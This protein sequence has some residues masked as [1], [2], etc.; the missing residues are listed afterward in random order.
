MGTLRRLI[1]A[2]EEGFFPGRRLRRRLRNAPRSEIA[3]LD[4]SRFARITGLVRPFEKTLL[5]APLS[6]RLCVYYSIRVLECSGSRRR[7]YQTEIGY[8]QE[9][10][11]F[12]L[13]DDTGVAVIDPAH[14]EISVAPDFEC[15]SK[16]AFD[17]D[18]RQRALLERHGLV[19][20]SWFSTERLHYTESIIEA[21]ERI[22]IL[23]AG[24]LEPDLEAAPTGMYRDARPM[25]MRFTGT[26][27]Y[28]LLISDDPRTLG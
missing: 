25:R 15:E 6:G 17:A 24:M 20:R 26:A 21:D 22:A 27:K 18:P 28:P 7:E 4:E 1:R 5:E 12:M 2:F 14:A 13:E 11:A 3:T 9:G 23:G 16:A 8:E 19:R 10:M